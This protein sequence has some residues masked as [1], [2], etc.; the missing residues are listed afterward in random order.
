[1]FD[2]VKSGFSD[3][4]SRFYTEILPVTTGL[5]EF[6]ERGIEKSILW[7]PGRMVD[8]AESMLE[9]WS[10]S[11]YGG[12]IPIILVAAARDYYVTARSNTRQISDASYVTIPTD[13]KNRV[14]KLKTIT[15]D[16][17]TQ[18]AIFAHDEPTARS[19]AMFFLLFFEQTGNNIFF[20]KYKFAGIEVEWPI[21]IDTNDIPAQLIATE[22][23]NLTILTLDVL[24]HVTIPIYSHPLDS[25]PND[26]LGT[27]GN[28]NDPHGYPVLIELGI[29][30]M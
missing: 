5:K 24:L 16:L 1:M 20:A 8:A 21:Q 25:E 3:Y 23:K 28:E 7:V 15:G 12:Q 6:K 14:F 4:L 26:G 29:S 2:A 27:D 17:R 18:L 10:K 11:G 19:I 30:A 13:P 22:V 9:R